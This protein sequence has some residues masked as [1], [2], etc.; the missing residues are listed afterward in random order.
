MGANVNENLDAANRAICSVL[1]LPSNERS[2]YLVLRDPHIVR[3][4]DGSTGFMSTPIL[5]RILEVVVHLSHGTSFR[6]LMTRTPLLSHRNDSSY[7]P[8]Q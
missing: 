8:E 2:N 6:V 5:P 3:A 4:G 7:F 1:R